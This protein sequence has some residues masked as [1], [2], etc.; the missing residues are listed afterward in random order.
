MIAAVD[1]RAVVGPMFAP[2]AMGDERGEATDNRVLGVNDDPS[3]FNFARR[4]V[5]RGR[6]G[7][8]KYP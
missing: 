6:G 8:R 3:L 5:F 7:H 4:Q 1:V 2:Q